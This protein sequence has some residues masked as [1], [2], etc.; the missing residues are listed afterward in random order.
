MVPVSRFGNN[1]QDQK[2]LDSHYARGVILSLHFCSYLHCEWTGLLW[3][4]PTLHNVCLGG[5]LI[6]CVVSVTI[7][8]R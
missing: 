6:R 4:M 8:H 5:R 7:L 1:L 3:K 2:L